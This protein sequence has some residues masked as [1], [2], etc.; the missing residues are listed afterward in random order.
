MKYKIGDWVWFRYEKL[1]FVGRV[2]AISK[3]NR[4]YVITGMKARHA[5]WHG[6][7]IAPVDP[8]DIPIEPPKPKG[9]FDWVRITIDQLSR[10]TK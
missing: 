4:E 7:I 1:A 5:V 9:L 6:D 8:K 10:G 2:R 3:G